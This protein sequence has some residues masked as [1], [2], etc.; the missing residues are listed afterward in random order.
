MITINVS[1]AK[2]DLY[3]LIESAIDEPIRITSKKGTV[4]MVSEEE[5]EG[6]TETLYL[7]GVPGLLEDINKGRVA[8]RSETIRVRSIDL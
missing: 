6:L 7:M 1:E 2:L 8:P 3:C 4:V 5:W